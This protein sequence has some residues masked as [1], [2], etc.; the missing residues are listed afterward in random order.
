MLCQLRKYFHDEWLRA[1][2]RWML[3]GYRLEVRKV[4][5]ESARKHRDGASKAGTLP[6]P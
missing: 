4:L 3:R 2:L 1:R 5:V 6:H